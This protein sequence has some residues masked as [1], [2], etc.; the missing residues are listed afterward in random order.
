ME[1]LQKLLSLYQK[2][3]EYF[4]LLKACC[5]AHRREEQEAIK[6]ASKYAYADTSWL[7]FEHTDIRLDNDDF[8]LAMSVP[9]KLNILANLGFLEVSFKSNNSTN[10]KV[11]YIG[12]MERM[13][14]KIEKFELEPTL[15]K[16][17]EAPD[18]LFCTIA[19]YDDIK[20]LLKRAIKT[21]RFHV[22]FCGSPAS[23]KTLF[24]LELARLPNSF[25]CLGTATSKAG[26][27]QILF[28]Q[29]PKLLL[30]DE[31]DKF[32]PRDIAILLSLAETGIVRETKVGR[33][34][35]IKLSTNVFAA[36]NRVHAIAKEMLSRFR[37]LFLPEYTQKQFIEAAAKVLTQREH[38]MPSLASYIAERT[39]EV[40]RDIREA[41]RI[42]K[43]CRTQHQVDLDIQL[44]QKYQGQPWQRA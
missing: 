20:T 3:P 31:L 1:N 36:A 24:L 11:R 18:D 5:E 40:T 42:A 17:V 44:L 34:R 33:Q 23:A 35:E 29:R 22:L 12:A 19:G 28:E 10:Y 26:L 43:V 32:E 14:A 30:C 16:E 41:V 38:V 13:L 15:D 27:C 8:K 37:I 21:E 2:K 39:W 4:T 25:Y 7:G 9:R 6:R